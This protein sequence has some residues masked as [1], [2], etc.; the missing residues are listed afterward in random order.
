MSERF[1]DIEFDF[2]EEPATE[3]A[4]EGTTQRRRGPRPPVRPPAGVT[5]LLRLIGLIA[6]A[7]LVVVLLVLWVQSCRAESKQERYESYMGS[8]REVA[9]AS[10]AVGQQFTNLLTRRGVKQA[11]VVRELNGL[12]Q[13]QEQTITRARE[14]DEPGRLREEHEN[15]IDSLELRADGLQLL[16][17][18]FARAGGSTK[19]AANAELLAQQAQRLLASDVVWD[20]LFRQP[21][22]ETLREQGLVGITVPDSTFLADRN[23][24]T[25]RG[26]QPILQ[27]IRGAATGG[28]PAGT[29][30]NGIVSVRALP[31]GEVLDED[32][33]NTIT[34]TSELSFEVTVEN[35]GDSQEVQVPVRLTLQQT[36]QPIKRTKNIDVID[37]GRRAT[38]VF[39]NLGAVQIG[40]RT[41]LTIVVDK[42]PGEKN[43]AN[44]SAEYE[45]TF[46]FTP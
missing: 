17:Q 3:E 9:R 12:V 22:L 2:F 18:G 32:S 34:A 33:E 7:I 23:L 8:V 46:L 14:I 11:D 5:P 27:R 25:A 39:G 44:N 21:S 42:V 36:P 16:A 28:I 20:D 1:G 40:Q 15:M 4:P 13:T 29:H 43:L 37:A 38:V 31:S 30:G 35:S 45:V 6:F 41:T 10:E 19:V 26:M 24:A